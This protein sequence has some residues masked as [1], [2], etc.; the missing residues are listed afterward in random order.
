MNNKEKF[1]YFLNFIELNP[2]SLNES[3]YYNGN[4]SNFISQVN[5]KMDD[6]DKI[7]LYDVLIKFW[8]DYLKYNSYIYLDRDGIYLTDKAKIERK[9]ILK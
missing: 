6:K 5:K 8:L 4:I 3:D 2:Y 7:H 9:E 1:I